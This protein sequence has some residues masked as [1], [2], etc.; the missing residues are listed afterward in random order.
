[1]SRSSWKAC[2]N[3]SPS[4]EVNPWASRRFKLQPH[5]STV[6]FVWPDKQF[7]T[8]EVLHKEPP[9]VNIPLIPFRQFFCAA[10]QSWDALPFFSIL[11]SLC[12]LSILPL[13]QPVKFFACVTQH[14]EW[15]GVGWGW[16]GG[17][18]MQTLVTPNVVSSRLEWNSTS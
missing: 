5:I 11:S 18:D 9:I 3:R 4:S 15:A 2:M 13:H 7:L 17:S 1:M 6:K 16:G 8:T 10:T 14:C 12:Q